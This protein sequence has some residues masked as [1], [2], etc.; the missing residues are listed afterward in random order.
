MSTLA[1]GDWPLDAD[2]LF[3]PRMADGR[4]VTAGGWKSFKRITNISEAI[5][6]HKHTRDLWKVN[7]SVSS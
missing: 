6:S 1:G 4:R 5:Q 2:L 7:D 3:V